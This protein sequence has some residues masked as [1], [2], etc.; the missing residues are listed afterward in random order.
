M[1]VPHD[2]ADELIQPI[3]RDIVQKMAPAIHHLATDRFCLCDMVSF[4][5][6]IHSMTNAG[7]RNDF[8]NNSPSVTG[9][10]NVQLASF[11]FF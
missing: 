7:Q 4:I 3:I 5:I 9:A 10:S 6:N 1:R 8:I 11:F 2:G